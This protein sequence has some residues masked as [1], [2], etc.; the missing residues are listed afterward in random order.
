M[1]FLFLCV[2]A[3]PPLQFSLAHLQIILCPP[4]DMFFTAHYVCTQ[5]IEKQKRERYCA[6]EMCVYS[7]C[8]SSDILSGSTLKRFDV[9]QNY[10]TV[11][12]V[13]G[14]KGKW[15]DCVHA[16]Q[17]HDPHVG[18]HHKKGW[19]CAQLPAATSLDNFGWHK[20]FGCGHFA[21]IVKDVLTES[22]IVQLK[23]NRVSVSSGIV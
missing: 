7:R 23:A 10:V 2:C 12:C 4:A 6:V 15:R 3:R 20:V 21:S 13:C 11:Q 17:V 16:D 18:K 19:W 1:G 14:K 5:D 22:L 8:L 9:L